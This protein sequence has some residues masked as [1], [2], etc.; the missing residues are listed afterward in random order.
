MMRNTLAMLVVAG[1][2]AW[3]TGASACGNPATV[4]GQGGVTA[5]TGAVVVGQPTD[6]AATKTSPYSGKC[7]ARMGGAGIFLQDGSAAIENTFNERFYLYTGVTGAGTVKVF[8]AKNNANVELIGIS[9]TGTSLVFNTSKA[10]A[11]AT[12]TATVTG[13]AANHWYSIETNWNRT[14]PTPTMTIKVNDGAPAIAEKTASITTG[15]GTAVADAIDYVQVGWV[16]NTGGTPTGTIGIDAYE[17]RRATAIG[18]L[19]NCDANGDLTC[20]ANDVSGAANEVLGVLLGDPTKL[21]VGQADCNADGAYN[22]NDVS[23]T[24]TVVLNDLLGGTSCSH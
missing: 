9:F 2:A 18:P 20:N 14:L 11:S 19:K 13:I 24:A 1:L 5:V 16:S 12:G 17:S 7:G 6:A 10:D 22:A 8:S 21:Q 3:S 23:A 4:W 15:I